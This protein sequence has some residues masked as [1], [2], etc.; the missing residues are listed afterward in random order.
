MP[1]LREGITKT[2]RRLSRRTPSSSDPAI[3][4]TLLATDPRQGKQYGSYRILRR[5]GAGGMGHV[6]LAL[7]TRLGRHAALKFLS[8]ELTADSSLFA[9]LE[10]EA[11]TAS[12]LNHP[13]ILTIYDIG[14]AHGEHYIASEFV[15]GVTLRAALDRR[16]IEPSNAIEIAMQ[17]ASAL[18]SAHA[19][20]VVHR[21]LKPGNIM[22]RPDGFVKVIDF[23]LAKSDAAHPAASF[24]EPGGIAGSVDYMSPEQARGDAV[25]SRTDLWSLGVVLY[26]MLAGKLPFS[27]ETYSHVIVAILDRPT[28]PLPQEASFPRSTGTVVTRALLKDRNKRYQSARDLLADVEAL[29]QPSRQPRD[30]KEFA[31]PRRKR[32]FRMLLSLA[33]ASALVAACITWWFL[34]GRE[35]L[36][37]P[38]WVEFAPPEQATASGNVK[39]A[40]ISPDGS[41][42]AYITRDGDR[43]TLR[44]RNL[45]TKHE[46]SFSPFEDRSF[47]L[48][49]SPDS[50]SLYYVLK[51]QREWGRLFSV[52]LS[53]TIPK[54]VLEDIDG[55][56]TFSPDGKQFA[57][58]RRSDQKRT[59]LESIIVAQA[60]DTGDQHAIVSR[61]STEI[62]RTLAW[63]PAGDRI[64]AV[65]FSAGLHNS[66]P[67]VFL[68]SPD[69][70]VKERFSDPSLRK[71]NSPIWLNRGSLLALAGLPQSATD[72]QAR[73]YELSLATARFRE[74]S[75][76]TIVYDSISATRT[77]NTL[78]AVRL[79]RTSSLWIANG[80][81]LSTVS[82]YSTGTDNIESLA[83]SNDAEI[84]F[85]S[86]RGGSANLWRATTSG[87]SPLSASENCV[88]RQP[89]SVPRSSLVA[90]SSNCAVGGDNF[91]LWQLDTKTGLRL[92]LTS[93]SNFDQQPDVTP[94]G[95]WIVYTSWPSNVPSL[96]KIPVGGGT[97]VAL[98]HPQAR[99]PAVSPNGLSVACQLRE[100]YDGRWRVAVLS[101]SDGSLRREFP[102]LPTDSTVRW[103]PDG[104]SLDYVDSRDGHSNLWRQPLNGSRPR[105]LTSFSSQNEIQDFAWSRNGD[106]LAY[107]Q[108]RAQ[109]DVILFHTTRR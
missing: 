62:G 80:K 32:S 82:Q 12:S 68:F 43:E 48:T 31:P 10:Q 71:L 41:Y 23:G 96:W 93:G 107:I 78:A 15:D 61:A 103:S 98:S 25:D 67:T 94:D 76:S 92:Q 100:N 54:L 46:S 35:Q 86:A 16:L 5:L 40:A 105:Q 26:E 90:Y 73:L 37:A 95:R 91:N 19:A 55:A 1:S 21:D 74:I 39:L 34:R 108:G 87:Y 106:K 72:P 30:W 9:R 53:S 101:L 45:A 60:A 33:G 3:D 59:S 88:E 64:A 65:L 77:G 66:Q 29:R 84:V 18:I 63:S 83:W 17:I 13:N 70:A 27:G 42:L 22:L 97:P 104:L 109:S 56:V 58:M 99:N 4:D 57:F 36:L 81:H 7:D 28:P 50:R 85:P 8:F 38:D 75:S 69:G 52:S 102:E 11:R 44:V 89:S 6:Y 24:S 14:Q 49:F 79:D 2:F 20:G 51:D 47:A